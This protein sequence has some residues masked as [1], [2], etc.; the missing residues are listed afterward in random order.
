MFE[1]VLT[2][3]L[4]F[5]IEKRLLP[6]DII[7]V[8]L[9]NLTHEAM[10]FDAYNY[11]ELSSVFCCKCIFNMDKLPL[12]SRYILFIGILG[13]KVIITLEYKLYVICLKFLYEIKLEQQQ[14]SLTF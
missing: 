14:R 3:S 8:L 1:L 12:I 2:L 10:R 13:N 4:V 5:Y 9:V 6:E 11:R 7:C